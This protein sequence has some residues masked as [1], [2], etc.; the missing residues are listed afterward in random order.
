VRD[1]S[2]I[3]VGERLPPD[4]AVPTLDLGGNTLVPGF[5]DIHVHGGGGFSL[6][7]GDPQD[8]RAYA[9]WVVAHGVTSVL[10]TVVAADT[11][12]GIEFLRAVAGATAAVE[13]GA[14]VLGVNLEGPFVSDKY[15]GAL[16]KTWLKSAEPDLVD[17]FADVAG[18]HLRL[19]TVAPELDSDKLITRAVA[20]GVRVAVG[21]SGADSDTT[22]LA[23][24]A[25][26]SH[27]THLFNAMRPFHHRDPGII[28][29]AFD[30]ST[31]TVELIADGVHLDPTTVR[32]AIRLFGP[33]RV[34]LVSDATP[35][36]G[37][38]RGVFKL[39]NDEAHIV[40]DRM[41]LADGTIAGGIETMDQLV[42]NVVQWK[43]A[44]LPEAVRMASTV[45]ASV[46]GAS[47]K[48]RIAPGYDADLVAL[49]PS[50]AVAATW[51]RGSLVSGSIDSAR[52]D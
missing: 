49:T 4:A 43:C 27:V 44:T 3:G 39:G 40:G 45:P 25:G 33:D 34:A 6:L 52:V 15:R 35:P 17:A 13:G 19:M 14:A 7:T 38:G 1:G 47:R 2:I 10:P 41:V 36:A 18:G 29:A 20:R 42:R 8:V 5:V 22:T 21:H 46:A 37:V 9:R 26:A 50:L 32:M 48:G 11:T 28:G 31:V 24:N 51:V 16:P 12:E 30:H 23:F